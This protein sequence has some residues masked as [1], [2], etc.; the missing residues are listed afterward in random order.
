MNYHHQSSVGGR[1]PSRSVTVRLLALF[2]L[3]MAV[4]LIGSSAYAQGAA[5]GSVQG[6]VL[7]AGSGKY[8]GKAR[9][10]V[11]GTAIETF[12]NDFG[13]YLLEGIP[14]GEVKLKVYYT[15]QVPETA[16]VAVEAGKPVIKNFVFAREKAASVK[17][18]GT[19]TLDEFVVSAQRFTN[20]SDIAVN[21]ERYSVNMKNVVASD[22]FGKIPEGNVGE[23]IK[24]LPGIQVSYGG[25]YSS[26]ADATGIAVRGFGPED[27]A[28][29]I[30]GVPVSSA[31][32]ASLS[33]AVGLDMLSINNAARIE[34]IKVPTPD[35]PANSVGG[36]VNLVSKTAF[37][38]AKPTFSCSAYL[39][40][41]SEDTTLARRTPGPADKKTFHTLPGADFFY[42]LPLSKNFGISITGATSN[43]YN[44]NHTTQDS[45]DYY[46]TNADGTYISTQSGAFIDLRPV[47][48]ANTTPLTNLAGVKSDIFNPTLK[49]FSIID[50]PRNSY[51]NSAGLKLDWRPFT[52]ATFSLGYTASTYT[53]TE[54]QRRMQFSAEK[55]QDWGPDY[56]IGRPYVSAAA[57]RNGVAMDPGNKATMDIDSRDKVG[58]TQSSILNLR[59]DR[60]PWRIAVIGSY[61][62]SHGSYRDMAN[63]H[64]SGLSMR[65]DPGQ[66][67]MRGIHDGIPSTV[68]VYDRDNALVDYTQL[69]NWKVDG[70]LVAKSGLA[71][72]MDT[73]YTYQADLRR[74]L[75]FIH[76]MDLAI[77]TGV[78][79]AVSKQEKWGAGTGYQMLYTGPAVSTS[80]YI[81]DVYNGIG[82]GFG[83][84]LQQWPDTYKFY[85]IYQAHPD[86]F[87]PNA[88]T[89]VVGNYS[90]YANQQKSIQEIKD[91]GYVQLEGRLLR[92]RLTVV[93]GLRQE[94]SARKGR[95][96]FT[97][98]KWNYVKNPNGTLYSD[99][100]YPS[101]VRIDSATSPLFTDAALQSRLTAAGVSYP[102]HVINATVTPLEQRMLNLVANRPIDQKVKGDPAYTIA[103]SFD[104]TSNL[105]AKVAWSRSFGLPSYE[106]STSGL[107]S[108]NG[109]FNMSETIP[110]T[111]AL[112][113]DGTIKVANPGLKPSTS[114]NWDFSLGYY[115]KTGGKFTV[116]AFMKK[117]KNF[118]QTVTVFN[119]DPTYAEVLGG[120]GLSPA[121]FENWTLTTSINGEG[122]ADTNG[123]EIDASQ[124]LGIF[125]AWGKH[126]DVFAN[127]THKK[128]SQKNL[129]S[130][131]GVGPSADDLGSAGIYYAGKR[132]AISVKAT[133]RALALAGNSRTQVVSLGTIYFLYDYNPTEIRLDFNASY[134]LS[135]RISLFFTARDFQ[136]LGRTTLR[137][138]DFGFV[139]NYAKPTKFDDFGVQMTF[140]VSATF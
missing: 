91:A 140:G 85:R 128:L 123:W 49:Q 95:G 29:M 51:R 99:S 56:M 133:Y 57:S 121:E 137:E 50:R 107:L 115:T 33:R 12:T 89:V 64:F 106:N 110:H 114:N 70:T 24:F 81:D 26:N 102:N 60:G 113:G 93:A 18:D 111:G 117:V 67:I 134:Q 42:A 38:Y 112:G 61:S 80:D 46:G 47:G 63:G 6:R 135:K 14:A 44:V 19:V 25:T 13:E 28:I 21:E 103:T 4:V 76:F 129:A 83:F 86:Y 5:T 82:P 96:P 77:K 45:W 68:T 71:E 65:M 79:R 122:T 104:V 87:D 20:A 54:V 27:T 131:E 139:P 69:A 98:G 108:G 105:V 31:S 72:S 92:N 53:S 119:T 78:R 90:S 3:A 52:G 136:G 8:L 73:E 132:L 94:Q 36:V 17:E 74:Q 126:F 34:L 1:L 41:N 62:L 30:D 11:E 125:G 10:T 109:A 138:D 66:V 55:P 15:G 84:A 101:G 35:M 32:P 75:D 7:N 40:M 124:N 48:G 39:S 120:L 37:E 22:A 43:Q 58:N 16:T 9:V 23:F 118:S 59:Y 97:D 116:S 2:A 88:S 100:T 130:G 127:Y